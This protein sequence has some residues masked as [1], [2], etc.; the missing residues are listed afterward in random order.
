MLG[1]VLLEINRVAEGSGN[2][3]ALAQSLTGDALATLKRFV[4]ETKP[5]TA[6]KAYSPQMIQR[7][8]GA[9]YDIRSITMRVKLG[10]T[11]AS[12]NQNLIFTF[13][14][15]G[16][17]ISVRAVVPNQDYKSLIAEAKTPEDSIQRGR[18]LDFLE[19]F[20]MAYNTKDL[21]YLD[22]V[23]S[24][25]ALIIVGTVLREN[26]KKDYVPPKS[27]L[28]E[29]KI[30]LVQLS[31]RE[32]L[33]NLKTSA[34]KSASFLNVRFE[35]INILQHDNPRLPFIYGVSCWQKWN[36][37]KYSDEGF[38]FLMMDFR[39]LEEPMV[40]VRTWQPKGFED[41]KIGLYDFNVISPRQ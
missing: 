23:F 12:E 33:D 35:D 26:T 16:T 5:T 38:L 32:Y 17:I 27:T 3:D 13:N 22:R 19:R 18:I 20:R 40:H 21:D 7:E 4:A 41:E 34:F 10:E 1:M 14:K 9:F 31:K 15:A 30:K 24:D 6:R 28:A 11:D 2:M 36:A 39:N 8:H 29:Q 37:A 25:D